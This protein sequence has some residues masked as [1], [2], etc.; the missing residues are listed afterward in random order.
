MDKETRERFGDVDFMDAE[1]IGYAAE[2]VWITAK[3]REKQ[4]KVLRDGHPAAA[5]VEWLWQN[6]EGPM[7]R[8]LLD[9]KG[10]RV[11]VKAWM[12]LADYNKGVM[13][14]IK[15]SVDYNPGSAQQVKAQLRA[16]KIRVNNVQ[17]ATMEV[18]ADQSETARLRL[19]YMKAMKRSGTY[20]EK[21]VRKFVED[22]GRVYSDYHQMGAI[23]GRLA[24]SNPNLQNIPVRD[25]VEYRECFVAAPG[26]VL[27]VFD[28]QQQEPRIVAYRSGD[29]ALIRAVN[30]GVDVHLQ[31][32]RLIFDD[33]SIVH[34]DDKRR[35]GKAVN[36][37]LTYGL[38]S[39]GLA[40]Q[41]G[42]GEFAASQLIRRYF[43]TFP[44][45]EVWMSRE[46]ALAQ[47]QWYVET[48][49]GRVVWVNLY[50]RQWPNNA[51]NAPIQGTGGDMLK[52]AMV[53]IYEL[54]QIKDMEF[55]LVLNV[56]DELVAEFLKGTVRKCKKLMLEAFQQAAFELCPG[57]KFPVDVYTGR[58]WAAKQLGDKT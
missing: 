21:W 55:P 15:D 42:M 47:H 22:D 24:S 7:L 49:G 6:V 23:T 46:R 27:S 44:G 29:K 9:W 54:F 30:S 45:V 56:H 14:R 39:R 8:V 51:V 10:V 11:D 28:Y 5:G 48:E 41:L 37:G 58:T 26:H 19:D 52:R 34:S 53:L 33:L 18:Y 2:D 13:Q 57:I 3:I 4:E 35:Q 43:H 36:L 32:A 40:A 25:S 16:E 17:A 50:N 12:K 20:G 38:S 31:V 1:M